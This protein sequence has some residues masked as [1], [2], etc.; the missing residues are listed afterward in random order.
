M[1]RMMRERFKLLLVLACLSL[2]LTCGSGK[3]NSTSAV[4]L[5]PDQV[6]QQMS[7][8]LGS[9][10]QLTFRASRRLDAA[11]IEGREAPEN[12]ELLVSVARP[13][14]VLAKSTSDDGVRYFY[15]D[16]EK[17]SLFDETMK[18]YTT[19]PLKGT[20]DDIAI[21]LDEKYGFTPPL[22]EFFVSDSYK[23]LSQNFQS[24]SAKG[25]ELINGVNCYHLSIVGKVA[26][27]ELWVSIK[28]QLPCRLHATFKDRENN[29]TLQ[30]D[31]SEWN[32]N[33]K[34]DE[35]LFAFVPPKDAERIDMVTV[36]EIRK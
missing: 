4:K 12:A 6:L 2:G 23:K 32:L 31:F 5:E 29:P 17:V 15:A 7:K 24:T 16:G 27:S 21:A 30:V 28:D 1:A 20:I 22:I 18:L 25:E 35:R 36:N 9:A 34:L 8:K 11:L 33:P 19:V 13:S 26:D 3:Q 10:S 14:K